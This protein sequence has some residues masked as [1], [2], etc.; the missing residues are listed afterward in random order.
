[1]DLTETEME[2][3]EWTLLAEDSDHS[4]ALLNTVLNLE[5]HKNYGIS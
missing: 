5:F 3:V 4:R 2:G 1:M